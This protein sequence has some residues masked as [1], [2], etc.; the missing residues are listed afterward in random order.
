MTQKI[1]LLATSENIEKILVQKY[2]TDFKSILKAL[3]IEINELTLTLFPAFAQNLPETLEE[4]KL[5][6]WGEVFEDYEE[7]EIDE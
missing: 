6:W 3:N 4:L 1:P 5:L 2:K 7:E